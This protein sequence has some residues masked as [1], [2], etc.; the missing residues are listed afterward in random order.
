MIRLHR[1]NGTEVVVNAELIESMEAHGVQTVLMLA[2]GNKINVTEPMTEV[3]Q[4]TIE[5][6]K[7]V[8]T[9]TSY[10]PQFLRGEGGHKPCHSPS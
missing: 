1:L 5:Y 8:F 4:K 10:L 7:T 6:K 9:G 3:I 2:T